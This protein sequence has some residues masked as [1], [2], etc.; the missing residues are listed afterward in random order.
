MHSRRTFLLA[1]IALAATAC[2]QAQGDSKVKRFVRFQT[3]SATSYGL[4]EEDGIQPVTGGLFAEPQPSGSRI[5]L[6]SA[7]LL[8]PC[9]P[10]QVFANGLNHG[11][12]LG[13]RPAP[14]RPEIFFKTISSMQHPGDPIRIPAGSANTHYEGELV[15]VIGKPVFQA[16]AEEAADAIFGVTCGND[17]S[18]R[19]WQSNDLQ[20]WRAKGSATFGP[21]GP[22]IAQGLDY[23]NL[24]LQTRINGEVVQRQS[25]SDLIFSPVDIVQAISASIQMY[26][27]DVVFTGTPGSTKAMKDGDVAEIEIEGIG[28]LSNPVVQG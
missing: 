25:T 23:N 17:V 1:S 21:M 26:P 8:Y 22:V 10:R 11:S 12:H 19:D 18:E 28:T 24:D 3:D 20:W 5:P 14:E 4:L 27:G 2:R 9:A 16:N 13:G 7:K 15:L 6:D